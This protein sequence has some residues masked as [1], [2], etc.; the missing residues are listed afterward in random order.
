MKKRVLVT[1]G[2]TIVPI[3]D[4][5]GITNIFKGKTGTNIAVYFA[6]Q[7]YNVTL[8]TSNTSLI[9]KEDEE[10]L[11][12]IILF[13]T[14]NGLYSEMCEAIQTIPY[15]VII[16]S[17]AVSDYKVEDLY[18]RDE[19]NKI[20]KIDKDAKISSSHE[21]LFLRMTPTEKIIDL[22]RYPWGFKGYLVKFKL[23]VGI[24]GEELIEIAKKSRKKSDANMIVANILKD[25][26]GRAYIITSDAIYPVAR[27]EISEMI[28]IHCGRIL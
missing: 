19:N 7:G 25:I 15:D 27:K 17:A 3:D 20:L 9:R 6:E 12:K 1:A 2:S 11:D 14:Y 28:Y 21:E 10:K 16:H 22:I 26:D 5:R 8:I 24:N 18:I 13:K 4:V 23:E